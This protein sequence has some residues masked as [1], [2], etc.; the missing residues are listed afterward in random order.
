MRQGKNMKRPYQK[1]EQVF[2]GRSRKKTTVEGKIH[3]LY[4]HNFRE[5]C[6]LETFMINDLS[7]LGN[8]LYYLVSIREAK[9]C[10]WKDYLPP[11]EQ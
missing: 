5:G 2:E 8:V 4:W 3:G 10:F 7:S 1:V 6:V 11:N 9:Y